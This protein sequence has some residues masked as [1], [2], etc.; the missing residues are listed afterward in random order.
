M[1]H[2]TV[3]AAEVQLAGHEDTLITAL[4]DA[5]V[6]VYGDWARPLVVIRLVGVPTGRWAVGG[7]PTDNP[8]P[9]VAF[10]IR[11]GALA[12]PDGRDIA[13]RL[14]AAVTDAVATALELDDDLRA[15]TIVELIPQ[16]D[17]LVGVGGTLINDTTETE[18]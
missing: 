17:E 5:V 6:G 10:G 2:L 4:T 15:T 8:A 1:P 16:P 7:V 3:Q 13:R 12:R 11:A 14:V 9:E 18:G